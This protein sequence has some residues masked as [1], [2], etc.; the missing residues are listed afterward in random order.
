MG[1]STSKISQQQVL[2]ILNNVTI[3]NAQQSGINVSD[4]QQIDITGNNN[5]ISDVLLQ[6]N[7][8]AQL[9]SFQQVS[10]Q[11]QLK[12]DLASALSAVSQANSG[13]LGLF[14]SANSAINQ[15]QADSII[16][17]ALTTNLQT[18][19]AAASQFQNISVT[20]DY[21]TVVGIVF[22]NDQSILSNCQFNATNVANVVNQITANANAQSTASTGLSLGSILLIIVG[23]VVLI[24]VVSGFALLNRSLKAKQ[25]QQERLLYQ[26]QRRH[27]QTY[28]PPP[29]RYLQQSQYNQPPPQRY[30][31]QPQ[32]NQ[33]QRYNVQPTQYNEE[34]PQYE[35]EQPIYDQYEPV[36]KNGTLYV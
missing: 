7:Q 32:Y 19:T 9:T 26:Q 34:Q 20:G 35:Q 21:N 16:S 3:S 10:N 23:V 31:Q 27:P 12:N 1:G 30:L 17:T 2:S 22:S 24:C 14:S 6:S 8:T 36:P 13:P 28:N 4:V 11:I 5:V 25:L 18:C 33:P 15:S 29:Q